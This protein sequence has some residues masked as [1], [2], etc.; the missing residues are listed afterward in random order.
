M[1]TVKVKFSYKTDFAKITGETE[2]IVPEHDQEKIFKEAQDFIG[3]IGIKGMYQCELVTTPS[4]FEKANVWKR[5]Y[6]S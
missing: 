5:D 4:D 2:I 1:K 6:E 3:H